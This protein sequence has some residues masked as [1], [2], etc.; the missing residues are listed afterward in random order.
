MNDYFKSDYNC[1]TENAILLMKEMNRQTEEARFL[2]WFEQ[3]LPKVLE[4]LKKKGY[5]IK[6][7]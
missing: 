3:L 2:A 4:S 6:P 7:L 5:V 1:T